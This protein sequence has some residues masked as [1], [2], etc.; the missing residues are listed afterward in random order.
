MLVNLVQTNFT[1]GEVSPRMLG[2]IDVERY[3]NGAETIENFIPLIHGGIKS[4][5][6]LRYNAT[7]K[8]SNRTCRLIRFEFSKTEA[9]MLEFGHQYIRFFNQDRTQ[10]M[11]GG[12]P[13]EIT[14]V[15]DETELFEIEYVGG[16][17]TIFLFHENHPVQRLRRFAN[18]NWVIDAAP[19][20]PQ[21]FVEQGFKPAATL[22]LS[23]ATVGTGRTFTAGSAVFLESDV[24]RRITY[25]GGIA[26]IT[27]YTSTTVVTCTIETAFG[28]TSIAS[29]VWLLNGTPQAVCTPSANGTIGES[30]T[31]SLSTGVV[32]GGRLTITGATFDGG[33]SPPEITFTTAASHGFGADVVVVD[34][35]LPAAYNGTYELVSLPSGTSFVVNYAPD[36]GAL[37]AGGTV[38]RIVASTPTNGWR[39]DDVGKFVS[40]NGGLIEIT[41]YTNAVSVSGIIRQAMTSDVGAQAGAWT[42]KSAIWNSD[43]GYPRSGTFF[44]QRLVVGGSP[45]YPHTIAASRTGEYLNFELGLADDD[46]FMFTL[47]VEEY[48]PILHVTKSKNQVI[49]LTS[50]N[51]FT[52]TGG[53]EAPM[54]PTNV[55]VSNPSDYGCN[56]V[57]PLRVDNE[58][59]FVNRTGRKFR[60]LGYRLE[61]DSFSS[62]DLTK[63][64]EHIT[65]GGVTDLA[66]QQ[67]PESIVWAVRSDGVMV[68]MSIDR[69][70]NVVAWARQTTD[71]EFESVEAIPSVSGGDEVWCVV[72]RTINGSTVRYIESFDDEA[73][74]GLHSAISD[75]SG[76]GAATWSGL[77]HLNGET[78]DIVA[79][80]VVMPQA[81]VAGGQ[82]TLDRTANAVYIGLP[83]RGYAKTLNPEFV[84]QL[85]SSQGKNVRIS[86]VTLR[87]LQSVAV[88]INGQYVDLRRFGSGLLDQAPPT[89]TGD[90]DVHSLGWYRNGYV[91][92]R[93]AN[94][95]PLH[96]LAMIIQVTV[97]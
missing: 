11:D 19:F 40:I 94:A 30:I 12:S 62:V 1:A 78:V 3:K 8:F 35:C 65:E 63:L 74:Y 72:K 87:M 48:D 97:N 47:D 93:Q 88:E 86:N 14:T 7:A 34:E 43:N 79:D 51:E 25:Q 81:V 21:P 4:A 70:E 39:S 57:R 64:S 49:A 58:L 55:Q 73:P 2:R 17:D 59:I 82:I 28:S 29:G 16:A 80:G 69:Q 20:S 56:A 26:L 9:N 85:G 46:A 61:Q 50:G 5:P 52:L 22:T 36:P 54:T 15:Y 44:Q 42:L 84:S 91:E 92:I 31:L 53:I 10:V 37:T 32:Y 67:E 75:T 33:A 76:P 60:A 41:S 23:A 96:V 77:S 83:S 71:G 68:T 90:I 13:Y 27:G 45:A 24:G 6:M 95:L 89:F 38:R 66:Y 18:D